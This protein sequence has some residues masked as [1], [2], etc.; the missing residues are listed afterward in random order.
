MGFHTGPSFS[1]SPARTQSVTPHMYYTLPKTSHRSESEIL[2]L[3]PE[4]LRPKL[5]KL[6]AIALEPWKPK[7]VRNPKP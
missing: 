5:Q 4:A 3:E 7:D 2:D 1:T 6:K